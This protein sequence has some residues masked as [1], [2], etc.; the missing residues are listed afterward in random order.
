[1]NYLIIF[2]AM[3]RSMYLSDSDVA[4]IRY[5][6]LLFGCGTQ[7]IGLLLKCINGDWP[8][9]DLV[10][11]SDT[12]AEPEDV[13]IWLSRMENLCDKENIPFAIVSAGNLTHA[14][15][16]SIATGTRAP[17][18]PYFTSGKGMIRR[19]CTLEYKIT[20]MNKYIKEFFNISRKNTVQKKSIEL[21]FGISVDEM[22]RM[23]VSRDWWAVNRYPLVEMEMNRQD[24]IDYTISCGY[25]A[26][27]RSS[28]YYCPFHSTAFW[29]YMK[30]NTPGDFEKAIAFDKV[31]RYNQRFKEQLF[32]HRSCLALDQIDLRT[33]REMGQLDIFEECDGYCGI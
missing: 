3:N 15:I 27:P 23:K 21:W 1:L 9:P 30:D 20:P 2:A 17:S 5:R 10:I 13:Y 31:I 6:V 12:M 7:S 26:P 11:F 16:N 25:H 28:C 8:I 19:Q 33:S 18:L 32:L 24:T 29:R 22:E 14:I 4:N